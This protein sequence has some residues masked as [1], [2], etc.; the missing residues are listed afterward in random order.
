M[1]VP[2]TAKEAPSTL[3]V[4]IF[5]ASSRHTLGGLINVMEDPELWYFGNLDLSS[6]C[7]AA[8]QSGKAFSSS[9]EALIWLT[10]DFVAAVA[11]SRPLLDDLAKLG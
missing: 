3:L 5:V 2:L 6:F 4:P 1:F 9:V 10:A 11:G 8:L 7:I